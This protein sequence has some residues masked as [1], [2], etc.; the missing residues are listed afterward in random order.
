MI[1]V[2]ETGVKGSYFWRDFVVCGFV[3]LDS[4]ILQGFGQFTVVSS[5]CYDK[6]FSVTVFIFGS[7]ILL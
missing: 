7:Q 6:W 2:W 4:G 5:D 3:I 1:F